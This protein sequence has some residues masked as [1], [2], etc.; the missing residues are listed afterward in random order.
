M[1]IHA[2]LLQLPPAAPTALAALAAPVLPH[3]SSAESY[4]RMIALEVRSVAAS[5][6]ISLKRCS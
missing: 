6:M 5:T 2:R 4:L 1:T 3:P